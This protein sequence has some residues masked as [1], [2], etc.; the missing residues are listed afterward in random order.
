MLG[1]N[2]ESLE[3]IILDMG[4]RDPMGRNSFL[5]V[6]IL[7]QPILIDSG[8]IC[9]YDFSIITQLWQVELHVH[10]VAHGIRSKL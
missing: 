10:V 9:K 1:K 2:A 8:L 3:P 4:N 5:K 6:C 7:L